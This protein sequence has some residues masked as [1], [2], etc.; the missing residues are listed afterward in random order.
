MLE[1]NFSSFVEED[2][3][4][5]FSVLSRT[6]LQDS[7]KSSFDTLNSAFQS[8]RLLLKATSSFAKEFTCT[9]FSRST[10]SVVHKK[11][12]EVVL[13]HEFLRLHLN[14][15]ANN[16]F[17]PY[18]RLDQTSFY[19]SQKDLLNDMAKKSNTTLVVDKHNRYNQPGAI[20]FPPREAPYLTTNLED[21]SMSVLA[22]LHRLLLEENLSG[23]EVLH[24][25]NPQPLTVQPLNMEV[26]VDVPITT[27]NSN[28][29]LA[30]TMPLNEWL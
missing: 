29:Q 19:P 7:H 24:T 2:G 22:S 4:L 1:T 11:D 26:D 20:R 16:I 30:N 5:S 18:P 10:H 21:N 12:A 13:L 25:L 15:L 14:Q 28:S 17:D 9:E 27:T 8:Q 3:E 6:V 23:L